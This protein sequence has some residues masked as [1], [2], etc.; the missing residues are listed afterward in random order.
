MFVLDAIIFSPLK[1][2]IW[3][4]KKIES[5]AHE[6]IHSEKDLLTAKLAQLY[7]DLEKGEITDAEFEKFEQQILDR[8]DVM[9]SEEEADGEK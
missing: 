1:S 3:L 9:V 6:E 4:A 5:A 2:L 8:L 7:L